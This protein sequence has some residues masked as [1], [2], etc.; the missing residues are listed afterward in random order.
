MC[1]QIKI[2]EGCKGAFHPQIPDAQMKLLYSQ[3]APFRYDDDAYIYENYDRYQE[4]QLRR[5]NL[6]N[7]HNSWSEST[8]EQTFC[9]KCAAKK[10]P[11]EMESGWLAVDPVP[12]DSLIE[13][14]PI[15]STD[16]TTTKSIEY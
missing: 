14:V 11:V 5:Q 1:K 15:N 9:D 8:R 3:V 4:S 13:V 7:Y 2:C 6:P 16:Q 10:K 12:N